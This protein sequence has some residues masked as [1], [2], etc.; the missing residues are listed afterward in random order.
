MGSK[1]HAGIQGN[2][3]EGLAFQTLHE[4]GEMW[5]LRPDGHE[6]RPLV[7]WDKYCAVIPSVDFL[8]DSRLA[9]NSWEDHTLFFLKS[10]L[11]AATDMKE[12]FHNLYNSKK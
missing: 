8:P 11:F 9:V 4:H 5:Q 1:W 3:M 6:T 12:I 2:G 10:H 7:Y